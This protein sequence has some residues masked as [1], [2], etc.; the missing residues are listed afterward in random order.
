MWYH[1][2]NSTIKQSQTIAV[3]GWKSCLQLTTL[4]LHHFNVVEDVGLSI[5]ASRSP[6]MALPPYQIS[7]KSAKQFESYYWGGGDTD[8]QTGD[9]INLL[10]FLVRRRK[11]VLP[12]H[13]PHTLLALKSCC[14]IQFFQAKTVSNANCCRNKFKIIYKSI[15]IHAHFSKIYIWE[16]VR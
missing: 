3:L 13:V 4:N 16:C 7:W 5:I 2:K 6:R 1:Q 14:K 12:A 15:V 11:I 10:S 9:L 8:R